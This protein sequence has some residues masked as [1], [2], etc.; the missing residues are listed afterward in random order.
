VIPIGRP[1][2]EEEL[3]VLD[4]NLRTVEP[5]QTGHLYIQ[6]VGLKSGLLQRPS[7]KPPRPFFAKP[8]QF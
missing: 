3:F 5:G 7:K 2:G 1:C 6:G 4:E 8:L